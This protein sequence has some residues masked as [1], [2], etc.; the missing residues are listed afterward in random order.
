[1]ASEPVSRNITIRGA[2]NI[3]GKVETWEVDWPIRTPR[4]TSGT[5]MPMPMK[6][7]A[8]SARMAPVTPRVTS[9]TSRE[10]MFG[11]RWRQ[12]IRRGGMPMYWEA[13]TK[14]RCMSESD[15]DLMRRAVPIQL[16]T[17]ST[18]MSSSQLGTVF[19]RPLAPPLVATATTSRAGIMIRASRMNSMTLSTL[20]PKN[21]MVQP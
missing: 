17:S 5:L 6:E 20:R 3:H 18:M 9:R 15:R 16:K 13:L 1:M 21:A 14:S 4:L 11:T 19:F 2:Q 12:T 7:N 8:T 10:P